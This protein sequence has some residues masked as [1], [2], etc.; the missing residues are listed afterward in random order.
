MPGRVAGI[1]KADLH[2]HAEAGPRLQRLLAES[3]G[4]PPYDWQEWAR[5][6]SGGTHRSVSLVLKN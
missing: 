4:E 1:P 2:L 3:K 5:L 6:I